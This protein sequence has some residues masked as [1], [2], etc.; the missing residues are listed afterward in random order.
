MVIC[1][2]GLGSNLGEREGNIKQALY[3]LK[4]SRKIEIE[5]ISSIIETEPVLPPHAPAQGRFLNAVVRIKTD[6]SPEELLSLLKEIERRMGRQ[7]APRFS[8]RII[9]LDILLY[10]DRKIRK[11]TLEIPHPQIEER[12][13]IKRLLKE[14]EE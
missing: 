11:K 9:D 2:I 1:Y 5:K 6:L 14:V 10:G 7:P 4:E 3:L 12:S 8:P 13:F